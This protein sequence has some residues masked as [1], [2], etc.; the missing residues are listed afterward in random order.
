VNSDLGPTDVDCLLT[1]RWV[2]PMTSPPIEDGAVW[3]RG[4]RIA[5]VGPRDAVEAEAG[6][7]RRFVFDRAALVPG[8]V[9]VHTHVELTA[10]RGFVEDRDFFRWIRK[11]TEAK[12]EVLSS[13]E[14]LASSLWGGLEATRA[15]VTTMGEV[16]DIG[17]APR[18]LATAGL[19]GVVYQEVF[20]PADEDADASLQILQQKLADH[21]AASFSRLKIGVSPH[22]PYS[23]SSTLFE[24]VIELAREHDYPVC[25]HAAESRAERDFVFR[26]EGP[27]ADW[28]RAR[29]ISWKAPR[30]S[31]VEYLERLGVLAT[32][33][34]LVHCI[35]CSSDDLARLA[36]TQTAVAHCPKSNAKLGHGIAPLA[37]MLE[38]KVRV[39]LGSDSVV[40]NNTCDL[41]E[42]LR[43]ASLLLRA[44]PDDGVGGAWTARDALGLATLAGAEALGL[45]DQVGSLEAGKFADIIAVD[46]S[47]PHAEPVHDVEAALVWSASARDVV[48]TMVE[49]EV[50]Y[51]DGRFSRLDEPAL[52]QEIEAIARKLSAA[53]HKCL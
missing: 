18:A 52:R 31:T 33:P 19:R 22:A 15:G 12:Y 4:G 14:I 11:L 42:E 39:G 27:F 28:L 25:V 35:D 23:V 10:L 53:F 20:G 46:L 32:R 37:G 44:G 7:C 17:A 49:G 1:A 13:E 6:P 41:F 47:G 50:L 21:L 5:S 51:E 30:C 34:L 2:L 3:V 9:N 40:S 29:G 38:A 24:K 36:A 43:L 48:F 16:C 8:L 45:A 26:G